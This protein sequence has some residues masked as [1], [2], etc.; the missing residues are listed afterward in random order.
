MFYATLKT[1][2]L[3]SVIV[4]VGGMVF[5]QFFLRPVAATLAPPE[6]V[7]LM[8]AVLG[9]F[10]NAVMVVVGFALASGLWMMARSSRAGAQTGVKVGM[11]LEWIAMAAL[12]LVMVGIFCYIRFALYQQLARA[13]TAAAWPT[14]GAVL[15]RIRTWV[16]VNLV[17]GVMIVAI[18]LLGA[19]S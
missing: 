6:R 2:H 10:F 11:P 12:G 1:I 18:T 17:I 3:L 14:G 5:V 4:W 7:C 13:V 8:H 9:R 19:S 15:A 16:I